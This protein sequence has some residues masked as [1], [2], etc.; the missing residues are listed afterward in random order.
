MY[1]I[2]PALIEILALAIVGLSLWLLAGDLPFVKAISENDI[3]FT[4]R[5]SQLIISIN[6]EEN[7]SLLWHYAQDY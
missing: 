4:Q 7:S 6:N 3:T 2:K 5:D 1:R